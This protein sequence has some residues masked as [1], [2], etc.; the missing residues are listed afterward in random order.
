MIY[1]DR[2]LPSPML[3]LLWEGGPAGWL[4]PLVHSGLEPSAHAHIQFRCNQVNRSHGGILVYFGRTSPLE[5]RGD[6]KKRVSFLAEKDY[7]ALSPVLFNM[8]VGAEE[9]RILR[10]R[11]ETHLRDASEMV[12]RV[13]V[14]GEA[15]CHAGMMR[16]YGL[17]FV[18]GDPFVVVDS[19][20]RAGFDSTSE[21]GAFRQQERSA[22][23]IPD[24]DFP[25]KLD[26]A[27]VLKSGALGLVEVKAK[28]E[29]LRR[30]ALQAAVH[31]GVF[32]ELRD[33]RGPRY[34]VE[35]INGMLEQKARVGMLGHGRF[36]RLREDAPLV[37]I[38]A[39]PE[40]ASNTGWADL[41]R[42]EVSSILETA[43][44]RLAGLRLW[45]LSAEGE[46][47][48]DVAA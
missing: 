23:G 31:V 47:L 11:I 8:K 45:R 25:S 43:G 46:L 32:R 42:K 38:L 13:F 2:R 22:L 19:E 14:S 36:P 33:Q 5:I 20:V 6:A 34:L 41:W 18:G 35:V 15:I 4:V 39:A 44:P 28:G 40:P 24:G 29:D 10:P 12:N 30:A 27:V 21:Q 7:V 37:P 26:A 16:R 3:E 9:L 48:E 1:F 17:D